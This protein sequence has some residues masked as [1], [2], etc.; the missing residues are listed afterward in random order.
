M[1]LLCDSTE[2]AAN[3][4]VVRR[5]RAAWSCGVVVRRGRAASDCPVQF[6]HIHIII[7][8]QSDSL[9]LC[10]CRQGGTVSP[11]KDKVKIMFCQAVDT[12]GKSV[13]LSFFK[14][15]LLLLYFLYYYIVLFVLVY[16]NFLLF[17]LIVASMVPGNNVF[18][19]IYLEV[20]CSLSLLEIDAENPDKS[21]AL[22]VRHCLPSIY[23]FCFKLMFQIVNC[24]CRV[25]EK[26][27]MRA[28]ANL[29]HLVLCKYHRKKLA[30]HCSCPVCG[31]FCSGVSL[32]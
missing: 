8:L 6:A 7:V 32:L 27:E 11:N 23:M 4:I 21:V 18:K 9:A 13:S 17:T 3:H 24:V 1:E 20:S 15:H 19:H 28:S 10:S 25:T 12:V 30:K 2:P 16:R 14:P 5:G 31:L 26:I 22:H 29:P